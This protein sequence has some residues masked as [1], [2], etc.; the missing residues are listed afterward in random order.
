MATFSTLPGFRELPDAERSVIDR[1]TRTVDVRRGQV[2]F[3]EG[4]PADAVW[5]VSDGKIHI[6]K[7][8][9]EGR[10]I[11][12]EVITA[13]ELFGAVV[14]IEDRPYPA[15]AIAA[16]DGSVWRLPASVARDLCHRHPSLRGAIM[17]HVAARLR[18]AHER[19]RSVALEP[20]EQRLARAVLALAKKIGVADRGGTALDVTRQELADMTGTTVETAIRVTGRWQSAGVIASS[21]RHIHLL[22][23]KRL[24]AIA[25]GDSAPTA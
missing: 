9:P 18:S 11:V 13:G 20:V 21:R 3:F 19:L 14:A 25:E 12:L 7:S 17:G 22:D 5:A 16:D 4:D 15:S 10:E 24:E 8:G 23:R 1:Q 6:F 2:L